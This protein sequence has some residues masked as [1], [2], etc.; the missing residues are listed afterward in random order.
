[1]NDDAYFQKLDDMEAT[2][3][4]EQL[5]PDDP[6]QQRV[7]ADGDTAAAGLTLSEPPSAAPVA[8]VGSSPSSSAAPPNIGHADHGGAPGDPGTQARDPLD[9]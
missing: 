6:E 9:N 2:Y 7:L 3:A 5:S 4:P 1:M 8:S